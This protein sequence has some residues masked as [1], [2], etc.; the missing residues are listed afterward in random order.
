[1]KGLFTFNPINIVS[2]QLTGHFLELDPI[3]DPPHVL[4]G[5]LTPLS[6]FD[7]LHQS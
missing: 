7:F 4:M 2:L 3:P 1:M 5:S 6:I